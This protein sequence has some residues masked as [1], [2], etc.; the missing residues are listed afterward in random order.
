MH[1]NILEPFVSEGD[2]FLPGSPFPCGGTSSGKHEASLPTVHSLRLVIGEL[3]TRS[4][5]LSLA[6]FQNWSDPPDADTHHSF[7]A[8]S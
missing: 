3:R 8:L 2:L 5:S 7:F 1:N 4:A 6:H